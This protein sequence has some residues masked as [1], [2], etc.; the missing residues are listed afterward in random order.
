MFPLYKNFS[1]RISTKIAVLGKTIE[2]LKNK[3]YVKIKSDHMKIEKIGIKLFNFLKR[4]F[5]YFSLYYLL[6]PF[7]PVGF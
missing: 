4:V 2:N 3:E 6:L 5:S 7:L 1:I